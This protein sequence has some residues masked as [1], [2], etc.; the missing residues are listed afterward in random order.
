MRID[1]EVPTTLSV[2]DFYAQIGAFV[3]FELI[4][5]VIILLGGIALFLF[6]MQ[7]MGDGLKKVAGGKLEVILYRLSNTPLKG[8]LLGT[9]VT[10]IIQSSS[11]TSVMVVGFVNAGMIKMKQA[12]G[13][14]MGAI[15]GTSVTGWVLCLSDI[16]G[17]AGWVDLLSTEVLA[18]VIGVIGIMFRMV[19]KNPTKKH[20]GDIMIGFCILMV[21]MQ[22]MSAAVAPLRSEP[23]FIDMLTKFSNPFIGI[24]IG[25]LVT[26]VLQ[27]ASATVGIL[28]ALSV[29]GAISFSVA[30]PIIMGIAVG[31]AMPVII[32]SFGATTDGK[33]TA[34][35]YLLVD[36]LGALIWAVVFYSVNHFVHFSFMDRTMTTVSIAF[37][38][39]LFRVATV[40]VLFPFIRFLE[41]MVC[42]IFKEVVDEEDKDIV[43][44]S[45]LDDRFIAH[46]TVAIEQAK[47]VLC[48]MA[49][50][51]QKNLIRSMELLD[52]FSQVKY[53]KIQRRED[54]VDRYEDK[55]GTYLVKITQQ[56]LTPGQNKEVSKLLHTISDF[57]R[58][59]DHAV[60]I[61][62]AAA[63]LFN[64]KLR[65]SDCA[66]EDVELMSLIMK[67]IVGNV[68][69]AFEQ[70][71]V[72]YAYKTEPLEEL[73]DIY[74][75]EMKMNHVKR[76]QKGECTLHQGFIFNDLLTDFERIADHCSNVAVAIIELELNV[77]DTHEYLINLKKDNGTN[78]DKYFEE[79]KEMFPLSQY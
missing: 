19:C 53:D 74:C 57:E 65:F 43:E 76:V 71:K 6:G 52:T 79:Y 60:N 27:S 58:I 8:V 30:L 1:V 16:S 78:F 21:G 42:A 39:S 73:V 24:L 46:P 3:S 68:I 59:S 55:L 9:G 28:Q 66:V 51:A 12:I 31:A 44:I 18:A 67:E 4:H 34:F 69:D 70:N 23:A 2:L 40:A 56:E 13:I 10:A 64:E 17:G 62:Q 47:T 25:L 77:F 50:M 26:A 5:I 20:I 75:D 49:H 37:V 7:L 22:N 72:E 38:N 11:A 45:V 36:A 54:K 41:K 15:I 29:T 61:S 35:V 32:S 63:E 33:R 48:S 14:I